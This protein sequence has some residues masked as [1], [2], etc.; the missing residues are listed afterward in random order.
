VARRS[1]IVFAL[2]GIGAY[3]LTLLVTLPASVVLK[4]RPWRSGIAGTVWNGEVGVAGGAKAEWHMAPLRSLTSL[5]YA[6]DWKASG[7]DTD[8]GGQLIAHPGGRMVLDHVSGSADAGLL[9]TVLPDLPFTCETVMQVEMKRIALGGGARMLDGNIATDPGNC[10]AKGTGVGAGAAV[11]VPA[12]FI[13]AEHLGDRTTITIAPFNQ[14]RKLLMTMVLAED[15][16]T[17]ISMTPD[18]ATV[19]PFV[20]MPGGARIQVAM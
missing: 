12:L 3:L 10:Q 14:R 5:A 13:N 18:G 6:A 16:G 19:L 11:A 1:I 4:N 2:I 8:L 17:D 15:G 9:R 20:G 7:P